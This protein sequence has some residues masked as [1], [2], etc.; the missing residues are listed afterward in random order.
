MRVGVPW[1]TNYSITIC[2]SAWRG[3]SNFNQK[4]TTIAYMST[5][6]QFALAEEAAKVIASRSPIKPLVAI[7]LG[8]G[9]GEFAD[10]LKDAIRIRYQE[11]PHFAHSTAVGH[12]GQ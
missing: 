5:S 1:I 3:T 7:V 4:G 11:I 8:S 9:L 10:E 12:A 2:I 6:N